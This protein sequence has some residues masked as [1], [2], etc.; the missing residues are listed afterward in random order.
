M[1]LIVPLFGHC[2]K[3]NLCV[4]TFVPK[5]AIKWWLI[6]AL[7]YTFLQ[8]VFFKKKL[9]KEKAFTYSCNEDGKNPKLYVIFTIYIHGP[10]YWGKEEGLGYNYMKEH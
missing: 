8:V 6:F 10:F 1:K 9:A 5:T 2:P 3:K 7:L 4:R